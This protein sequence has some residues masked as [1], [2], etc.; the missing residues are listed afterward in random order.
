VKRFLRQAAQDEPW[1]ESRVEK[2]AASLRN[3][4]QI[5]TGFLVPVFWMPAR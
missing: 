1:N 5:F 2:F 3:E 4:I